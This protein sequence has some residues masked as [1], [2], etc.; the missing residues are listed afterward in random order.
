MK[1]TTI[2]I[3]LRKAFSLG[4]QHNSE[5]VA[6]DLHAAHNTWGEFESLVERL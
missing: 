5:Q 1:N 3:I 2:D 4:E 6:L